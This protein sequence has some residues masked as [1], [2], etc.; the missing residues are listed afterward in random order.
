M[1]KS[2]HFDHLTRLLTLE[3]EEEEKRLADESQRSETRAERSGTAL[4]NLVIRDE[5]PA[6][7]GRVIVTLAKRNQTQPLP[8]HRLSVGSP[9]LMTKEGSSETRVCRGVVCGRNNQ[10]IQ[11]ALA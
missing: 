6:L 1:A 3:A 9:V 7:G 5:Q 10:T 4:A 2:G 8:W 11:V